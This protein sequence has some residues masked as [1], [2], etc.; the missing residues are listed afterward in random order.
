MPRERAQLSIYLIR[1]FFLALQLMIKNQQPKDGFWS[2]EASGPL[3]A[4][5]SDHFYKGVKYKTISCNCN[6]TNCESNIEYVLLLDVCSLTL[7]KQALSVPSPEGQT[8][9]WTNEVLHMPYMGCLLKFTEILYLYKT[10]C[11]IP[12]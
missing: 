4:A 6:I 1:S 5:D 11:L 10:T 2:Y 7:G 9:M 3:L 8:Y 12:Y